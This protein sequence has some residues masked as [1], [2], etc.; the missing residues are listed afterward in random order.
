MGA[1]VI[2]SRNEVLL[3]KSGKK[4]GERFGREPQQASQFI[5]RALPIDEREHAPLVAA[6]PLRVLDDPFSPVGACWPPG[7]SGGR[8]DYL[9]RGELRPRRERKQLIRQSSHLFQKAE[10]LFADIP[11]FP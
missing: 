6:E 7:V 5:H 11:A 4:V 8:S 9:W 10:S 1:Q 2:P 3:S